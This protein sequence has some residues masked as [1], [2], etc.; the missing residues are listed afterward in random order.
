MDGV[1]GPNPLAALIADQ[2]VALLDG[3][4]ATALEDRGFNLDDP[5]WSARLLVDRPDAVAAV[6][7]AYLE[8]GADC[9][10]TSSYQASLPGFE[11][12]G[13]SRE[14]AIGLLRRSTTLAVRE[15]DHFPLPAG[16]H[17]PLVAASIGP[18]GAFLA[19]GSEYTGNPTVTEADLLEFHEH[20]WR[21][22]AQ[23]PCDLLACET[24]PSLRE[25]TV[26]LELLDQTPDRWAWFS[27]TC[28]DGA[29]L[30]D[31]TPFTEAVAACRDVRGVAAVGVNCTAP[32]WIPALIERALAETDLPILV[33][34]NS[35]E[36]YDAEAGAW[37]P[38]GEPDRWVSEA[39]AWSRLG[40]RCI[41][42]CCRVGPE[43]IRRLRSG[44]GLS[45]PIRT[46]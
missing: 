1:R 9:I 41:G 3:G 33:Y 31:G 8:A 43:A 18:F 29:T 36:R 28:R 17:R 13:L 4:L 34:P 5:L 37:L 11:R 40:A 2:G 27:F 14:Q 38:G 44:L 45:G 10:T 7:R 35:G 16:R 21:I 26:L 30:S 20:R 15:R 23:T 24:L 19:D 39:E 32:R 6:H 46:R 42:G 22:L 25:A 12:T